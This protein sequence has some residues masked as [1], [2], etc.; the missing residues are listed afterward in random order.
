MQ[1]IG[2]DLLVLDQLGGICGVGTDLVF[3]V[4]SFSG[5][6]FGRLGCSLIY[7]SIKTGSHDLAMS[8][9]TPDD[10]VCVGEGLRCVVVQARGDSRGGGRH[11]SRY[12]RKEA[13]R[14]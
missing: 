7:V 2:H 8:M 6:S 5:D 11:G 14:S 12:D 10:V 13:R 9:G 1:E 3:L 4:R